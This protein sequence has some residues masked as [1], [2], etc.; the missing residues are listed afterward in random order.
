M[1]W[2]KTQHIILSS[3]YSG[4]MRLSNKNINLS[5]ATID[6]GD[7]REVSKQYLRICVDAKTY[8]EALSD[9]E[10]SLFQFSASLQKRCRP[11][12][13]PHDHENSEANV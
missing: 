10:P 4:L 12:G 5:G 9:G 1:N 3:I 6:L 8:I 7:E 2:S 11:K 13:L